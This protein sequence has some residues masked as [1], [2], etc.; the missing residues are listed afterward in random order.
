[1]TTRATNVVS[2]DERRH[3]G[4][5]IPIGA[6]TGSPHSKTSASTSRPLDPTP[7]SVASEWVNA[8]ATLEHALSS[9][10]ESRG[11]S[12]EEFGL[13][14]FR[15]AIG[16]SDSGQISVEALADLVWSAAN[17]LSGVDR[18]DAIQVALDCETHLGL[19]TNPDRLNA[20][21]RD[22]S[23]AVRF[24]GIHHLAET[25][26]AMAREYFI[27][28]FPTEVDPLKSMLEPLRRRL[29]HIK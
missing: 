7:A 26:A 24:V 11:R 27:N 12:W 3:E 15:S 4:D 29:L 22:P 5:W 20:L 21:L 14:L 16:R 17:S 9:V 18:A 19:K 6:D 28:T 2:L 13:R 8:V 25:Q 1:M 23:P 10:A